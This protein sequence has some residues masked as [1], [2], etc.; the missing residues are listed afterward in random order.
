VAEKGK[1]RGRDALSWIAVPDRDIEGT[2]AIRFR[3]PFRY[4][5]VDAALNVRE[6]KRDK[7]GRRTG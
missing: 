4:P 6:I 3:G 1:A 5:F 2:P 7:R